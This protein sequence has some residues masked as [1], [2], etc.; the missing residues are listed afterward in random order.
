MTAIETLE[1]AIARLEELRDGAF[2]GPYEPG[3]GGGDHWYLFANDE[4]VAYISAND[5]SDEEHREPTARLIAALSRTMDPMIAVLR[6]AAA[7]HYDD[8]AHWQEVGKSHLRTFLKTS[9]IGIAA[10]EL[11]RS[12]LGREGDPS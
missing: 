4:A 8:E 2:P 10:V 12:V 7:E 9:P 6:R 3:V 5:G 11:A 1:A